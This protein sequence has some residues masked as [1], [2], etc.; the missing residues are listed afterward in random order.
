MKLSLT[1]LAVALAAAAL[2]AGCGGSSN[3]GGGAQSGSSPASKTALAEKFAQCMRAHGVPDF[4]D[5]SAGG[6]LALSKDIVNSPQFRSAS[7]ACQSV[8]PAGSSG[9][10]APS[11]ELQARLLSFA[12]CMR[13]HGVSSFPDP[14]FSGGTPAISVPGGTTSSPQFQRAQQA[15]QSLTPKPT[16]G[17]GYSQVPSG[18]AG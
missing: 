10:G 9:S 16:G 12:R 7:Q 14:N 3:G 11:P 5:P 2:L 1:P 17:S 15:C 4:P 6:G 18:S 8:V 13:A